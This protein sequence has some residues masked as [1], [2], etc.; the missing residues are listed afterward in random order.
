[1]KN[2]NLL[3][4]FIVVLFITLVSCK[5]ETSCLGNV[6]DDISENGIRWQGFYVQ[7]PVSVI[8]D[9]TFNQCYWNQPVPNYTQGDVVPFN[10]G[11]TISKSTT[12][13]WVYLVK[14]YVNIDS[15]QSATRRLV[16]R[17]WE[18]VPLGYFAGLLKEHKPVMMTNYSPIIC[19]DTTMVNQNGKNVYL[20]TEN[21]INIGTLLI[22]S[23]PVYNHPIGYTGEL[24]IPCFK[25]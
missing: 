23:L 6:S 22:N 16:Q 13:R 10:I 7:K 12:P 9:T 15:P 25:K 20:L 5:K 17:G 21:D 8:T 2:S 4:T 18:P 14:A 11:K 1:M 3:V 19:L 24:L